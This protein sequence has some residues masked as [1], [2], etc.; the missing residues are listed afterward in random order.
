M[1]VGSCNKG[2]I[3]EEDV[4]PVPP[5]PRIIRRRIEF[6][7]DRP[8]EDHERH[9]ATEARTSITILFS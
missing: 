2:R 1:V 3:E 7:T 5:D 4:L 9:P 8:P 6:P